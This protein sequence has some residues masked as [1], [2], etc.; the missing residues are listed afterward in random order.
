MHG[1]WGRPVIWFPSEGGAPW[2][3]E[4][5]GMLDAV[6][7]AIDDGR[8][9][10]SACR[11]STRRPGRR[12]GC[13]WPTGPATTAATR[14][15]SSGRWCRSSATAAAAGTTSPLAGPV[16]GRVPRGAVRASASAR[17]RP[18]GRP[19]RQLR[20][21]D[22][23]RLGSGRRR[24]LLHQPDAVRAR[25]PRR[26]PGLPAVPAG[27]TLVVGSG[28]WEDSTGANDS[29]RALAGVLADKQI[30]HELYSL[31][32]RSGR[33]TGRAGGRRPRSTCPRWADRRRV[34][35][36][37]PNGARALPSRPVP[38]RRSCA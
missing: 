28:M 27:L 14:T 13:R 20:P 18:G 5:N 11:R 1:H 24:H 30:P 8:S 6:R 9:P 34:T 2:D 3:F 17:V 31:G 16:D 33:T 10:S 7:P 32:S 35:A 22:L 21:L 12:P 29:T 26:A 4:A 37:P 38:R 36:A 19:L 23:A 25:D 15:G